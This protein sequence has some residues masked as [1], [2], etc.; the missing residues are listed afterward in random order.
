MRDSVTG[1][2]DEAEPSSSSS[3]SGFDERVRTGEGSFATDGQSS[4]S[5]SN[6]SRVDVSSLRPAKVG[7]EIPEERSSE[8]VLSKVGCGSGD[9]DQRS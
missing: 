3:S 6:S 7:V 1:S 4:S 2:G 9:G 8:A 5:F